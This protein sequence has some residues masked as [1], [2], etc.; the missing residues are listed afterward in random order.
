MWLRGATSSLMVSFLFAFAYLWFVENQSFS[1]A[2]QGN[3]V[4]LTLFFFLGIYTSSMII[5]YGK[6]IKRR[7]RREKGQIKWF[8]P[9]KGYGFLERDKGGDL[10]IHF[11]SVNEKDRKSLKENTRVSYKVVSSVKGPQAN[12]IKII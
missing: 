5:V 11:A 1:Q 7:I 6:Q 9:S 4:F 2:F 12:E 3:L 8:D 10:F